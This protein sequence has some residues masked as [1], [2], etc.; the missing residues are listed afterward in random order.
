MKAKSATLFQIREGKVT[1]LVAAW[2]RDRA[3]AELG[4]SREGGSA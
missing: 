4:L 3:V 1:K 2:D